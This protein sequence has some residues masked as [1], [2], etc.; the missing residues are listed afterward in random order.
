M[1]NKTKKIIISLVGLF[2]FF[3]LIMTWFYP[4]SVFSIHKS[5]SFT[6]DPVVVDGYVKDLNEFKSSYEKDLEELRTDSTIDLTTDRTQYL[7]PLFEQDWLLSKEPVKLSMDDLDNILLQV[8]NARKTLLKLLA[9]E[10]YKKE[11]RRY[12]VDS[13][14]NI[15]SLEEEIV[16]IKTGKAE[17]RKTLKIQFSNLHGSFLNNF[18]MF[19][20]FYE[21]SRNE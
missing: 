6:P 12:L 1:T 14:R 16:D 2:V 10:D 21:R 11:Q 3:I 15:L 18:L 9:N 8:K 17:S 13:I 5:Y 20:I 7:L 19:E 4:Y